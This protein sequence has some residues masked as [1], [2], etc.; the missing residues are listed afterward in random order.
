MAP[1]ITAPQ[2]GDRLV[3]AKHRDSVEVREVIAHQ[4]KA[5]HIVYRCRV[6]SPSGSERWTTV[7][8]VHFDGVTAWAV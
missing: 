1:T 2:E 3:T 4:T 8:G 5:G 6:A 7:S